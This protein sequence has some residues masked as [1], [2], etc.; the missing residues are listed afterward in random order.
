[1]VNRRRRIWAAFSGRTGM[2]TGLWNGHFVNVP[3]PLAVS[4]RK[5]IDVN[6]MLWQSILDNTG[7]PARM[8]QSSSEASQ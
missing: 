6:G 5:N 8:D 4:T 3:T 7:Q 2:V 1:M